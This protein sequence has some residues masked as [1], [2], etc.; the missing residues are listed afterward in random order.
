MRNFQLLVRASNLLNELVANK[1]Q[2]E[3]QASVAAVGFARLPCPDGADRGFKRRLVVTT[4]RPEEFQSAD[5]EGRLF[6]RR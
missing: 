4:E 3:S 1:P 5:E 2:S 6:G